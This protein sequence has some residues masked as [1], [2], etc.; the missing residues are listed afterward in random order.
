[1][2]YRRFPPGESPVSTFDFHE[3]RERAAHLE[4]GIHHGRM[5][6]ALDLVA[7]VANSFVP[8]NVVDLGCGD[9][10]LVSLIKKLNNVERVRGYDFQ[11]SNSAG[12]IER[13]VTENCS[14][15]NFVENWSEVVP[16]DVYVIT[17]VLEH[18]EDP[19]GMV[20]Y[21]HDRGAA[22]VCS[23]PWME[24]E[25]NID[26]CHAWAWDMPGYKQMLTNA[27]FNVIESRREGIFQVHLGVPA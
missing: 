25:G 16:A 1:M 21:I 10:G 14:A 6:T 19:H 11:P 12:W 3:H 13:G 27:G 22:I 23:S 26:A 17:E 8:I 7:R 15:L 18:L 4:Q 2:E 24:Y 20:R 9:G 5:V